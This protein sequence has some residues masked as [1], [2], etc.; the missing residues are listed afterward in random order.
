MNNKIE[1]H[2]NSSIIEDTFKLTELYKR[3]KKKVF[4]Q[5]LKNLNI[6]LSD[7]EEF[8]ILLNNK[9][10]IVQ[11]QI[12]KIEYFHNLK[13]NHKIT[14][15]EYEDSIIDFKVLYNTSMQR[16]YI[17]QKNKDNKLTIDL[18]YEIENLISISMN[19]EIKYILEVMY[20][21]RDDAYIWEHFYNEIKK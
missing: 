6:S 8:I 20:K 13:Y 12:S 5:Y 14:P 10:K 16:D 2:L 17:I 7:I 15:Q 9:L 11:N 1:D 18:V 3:S 4:I 19:Y 21:I